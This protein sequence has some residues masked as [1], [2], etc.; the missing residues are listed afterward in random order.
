[1]YN[2]TKRLPN[3]PNDRIER[4]ITINAPLETVFQAIS[5]PEKFILWFSKGVEGDFATGSQPILDEGEY[6]HFRIAIVANDPPTYFAWRWVSGTAFVPQ[7]FMDDPL[8]HPNTLVEFQLEAVSEGTRV[9]LTETGFASLPETY[10]AQNHTDN[11][12]GWDYQ[13]ARLVRHAETGLPT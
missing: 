9:T 12:G 1:M 7:G 3:M 13:L 6:G 5:T 11:S 10:A 8:N 4:V 2:A